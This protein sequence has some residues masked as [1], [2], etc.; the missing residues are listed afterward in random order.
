MAD[1]T[2]AGIIQRNNKTLSFY[3]LIVE[4]TRRL[5]AFDEKATRITFDNINGE[6]GPGG[7]M[8]LV[9]EM[10]NRHLGPGKNLDAITSIQMEKTGETLDAEV[11]TGDSNISFLLSS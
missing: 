5:I 11:F 7:L 8:E 10:T 9:H 6:R 2:L 1:A 4:V 3:S